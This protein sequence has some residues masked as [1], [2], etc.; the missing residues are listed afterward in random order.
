MKM[1]E[2]S[3]NRSKTLWEK[4]KVLIMSNFSFFYSVHK[5]LVLQ[6]RKNQGL[7]GKGLT[8]D[9]ILA[10]SKLKAFADDNVN[11]E[12]MVHT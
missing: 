2:S 12:Q 5:R 10:L 4:E 3:Q 8:D 6:A 1:A 11:V 9:K 7:F